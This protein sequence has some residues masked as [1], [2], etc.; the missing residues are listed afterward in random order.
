VVSKDGRTMTLTINGTNAQGE[1]M[2]ALAV[3]EKQ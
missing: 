1:K 2:L 3:Y